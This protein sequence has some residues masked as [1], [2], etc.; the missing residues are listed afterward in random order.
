MIAE[1]KS[2][3]GSFQPEWHAFTITDSARYLGMIIGPSVSNQFWALPLAKFKRKVV[4]LQMLT[5]MLAERR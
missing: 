2:W 3:L 5:N 4:E 1:F